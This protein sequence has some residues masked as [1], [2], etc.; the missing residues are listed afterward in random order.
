ME[1]YF[2]FVINPNAGKRKKFDIQ[3]LIEIHLPSEIRRE[4]IIWADKNNFEEVRQKIF[5]LPF[6]HVIAVG[7]DGTVNQVASCLLNSKLIFGILPLGSGNG[8]ARSLGIPMNIN[9]AIKFLYKEKVQELDVGLI[10]NIP[11]FCTAGLGFD[12]KIGE[13]FFLDKTRGLGS[14]VKII[15]REL[16]RYSSTNYELKVDGNLLNR[17][18]FLITF[19]NCGQYGNDFYIAPEAKPN[20]GKIHLV[21]MRPFGFF[22]F[23]ELFFRIITKQAQRS[24]F[25]ET[26]IC[27]NVEIH[28]SE[29]QF[30]HFD[31]EPFKGSKSIQVKVLDGK[32]KVIGIFP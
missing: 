13:L 8:L 2:A 23:F 28:T 14:Y 24:L 25:V 21:I 10:N 29:E 19:A 15:V 4:Y 27:Q 6:T 9:Q 26:I 5:G 11:F 16:F 7:G 32:Q 3:R 20:D 12:A 22:G 18:A 17:K 1:T 30:C 31:G